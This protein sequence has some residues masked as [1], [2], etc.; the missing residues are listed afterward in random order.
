MVSTQVTTA[1][2]DRMVKMPTPEVAAQ[3][4]QLPQTVFV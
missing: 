2:L 3:A 4:A 1:L